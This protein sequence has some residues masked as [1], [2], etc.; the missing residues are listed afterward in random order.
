MLQ[1]SFCGSNSYYMVFSLTYNRIRLVVKNEQ[2]KRHEWSF[3]KYDGLERPVLKGVVT[4]RTS[5]RD[6]V[7]RYSHKLVKE[8]WD[9][10]ATY[11]YTDR[12]PMGIGTRVHQVLFYDDYKFPSTFLEKSHASLVLN[13]AYL[14]APK[15]LPTAIYTAVLDSTGHYEAKIMYYGHRCR[16]VESTG[17]NGF[18][19]RYDMLCRYIHGVSDEINLEEMHG[20]LNS[21]N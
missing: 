14:T 10:S 3:V 15:G 11:G 17:Y 4:I 13:E 7:H 9:V 8:V 16:M 5:F 20:S 18:A 1:D 6:L 2:R 12:F 19:Y 21:L